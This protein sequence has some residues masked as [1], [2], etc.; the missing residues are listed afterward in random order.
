MPASERL[1]W[2]TANLVISQ[3]FHCKHWRDAGTCDAFPESVP[4]RI[5]TNKHDHRQPF[6]GDNGILFEPLEDTDGS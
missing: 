6:P 4:D 1:T 3:C 2:Q 5:L